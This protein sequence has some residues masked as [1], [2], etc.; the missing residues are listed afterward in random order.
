MHE[1]LRM[2]VRKS[3]DD[4]IEHLPRL[5]RRE[6]SLG[7]DLREEF[8]GIFRDD[9]DEVNAADLRASGIEDLDQVRMGKG[10][11]GRPSGYAPIGFGECRARIV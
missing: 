9:I 1:S 6:R 3:I 5:L 2:K 11:R 7:N 10:C 4:G 8:F